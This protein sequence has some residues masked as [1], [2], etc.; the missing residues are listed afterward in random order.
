MSEVKK[1]KGRI[2]ATSYINVIA[3]YLVLFPHD[4]NYNIKFIL[5][6]TKPHIF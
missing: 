3:K 2:K 4:R 5:T 6:C 1:Q